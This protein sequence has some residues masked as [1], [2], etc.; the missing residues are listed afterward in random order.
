[1]MCSCMPCESENILSHV[2]EE[3]V[4]PTGYNERQAL[5]VDFK[6]RTRT[7]SLC[8]WHDHLSC[9]LFAG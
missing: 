2:N 8:E 6:R 5:Y 1:M 7:L 3:A 9:N 4:V